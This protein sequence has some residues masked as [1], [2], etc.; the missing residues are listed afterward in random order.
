MEAVTEPAVALEALQVAA[1]AYADARTNL[2]IVEMEVQQTAAKSDEWLAWYTADSAAKAAKVA[3]D[4]IRGEVT[5]RLKVAAFTEN[6][7]K[8][9]AALEAAWALAAP[10]KPKKTWGPVQ[11]RV[12]RGVKVNDAKALCEDLLARRLFDYV[13]DVKV[14]GKPLRD[15]LDGSEPPKGLVANDA[16]AIAYSPTGTTA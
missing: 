10:H 4:A 15:L 14:D 5:E 6:L 12:T 16:I 13:K 7:T 2:S 9:E 11:I 8:A 3:L 1:K